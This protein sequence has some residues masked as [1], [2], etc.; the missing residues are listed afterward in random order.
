MADA[1]TII[2]VVGGALGGGGIV[3]V[4]HVILMWRQGRREDWQTFCDTYERQIKSAEARKDTGEADRVRREYEGQL[5]AWRA[6]KGVEKLAPREISATREGPSLTEEEVEG[7]KQ[8]LAQAQLLLPALLSAE[9]YF[10]RG[11]AHYEAGQ[12]QEALAAYNRALELRPDDPDTLNNRG[13]TLGHLGRHEEALADYNR[14]LDLRRDDPATLTNRGVTLRHLERYEEALADHNR[15]LELRP[16]DP[17]TLTNRGNSL[18]HLRRYE[19]A[20]AEHNRSLELRPD[21]PETLSNRGATL[22]QLGRYEEA[23]ADY[24]RV[25]E[26]WPDHPGT[27]YNRGC[28][29]AF[30]G[31]ADEAID[32]LRRAI[33]G[34]QKYRELARKD[35]DFDGIRDDPRFRA[36]VREEQEP[37]PEAGPSP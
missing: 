17:D 4:V 30:Q 21:H 3:S 2:A 32:D 35:S 6:Q 15:S 16:D 26:L 28:L 25:L 13:I 19:E 9:D 31:K 22:H 18:Y 34:D 29:F 23:L 12:Y 11:N 8:L 37:P 14:S 24:N 5:E 20:L 10:L 7:L 27:Y 36:L 1:G 33:A